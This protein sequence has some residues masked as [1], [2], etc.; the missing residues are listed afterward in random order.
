VAG[1]VEGALDG[2]TATGGEDSFVTVFAADGEQLWTARRGATGDDRVNA[3]AFASD[4]SVIVAGETDSALPGAVSLGQSDGYVRGYSSAG[5]SLFTREFGTTGADAASAL[6]VRDN[7]AGGIDIFTGGVENN[8]GIVRS[9]SYSSAAGLSTGAA[10]DIGYFHHG[11]IN[12]LAADG[13]ELYVAGAVG[14]DRLTLGA[15]A[16]ASVAGNEGFVARINADLTSS[17]LDRASYLG[18]TGEDAVTSL[19]FVDG[20]LYAAGFAGGI[21]AGQGAGGKASSFI[22]RLDDDG[23]A[24]WTRVF[25]ASAGAMSLAGLAVDTSGASALDALG[26][27]RGQVAVYDS[28]LLT[29]RSGLRA[30]DEFK[31][32]V[33]GRRLTTI[34]ISADETLSSL[35][36]KI[37]RAV[38]GAGRAKVVAEN[39]VERIVITPNTGKAIRVDPGRD[40]HDALG[41][42]GFQQGLIAKNVE[43]FKGVKSYGLSIIAQDFDLST[44]KGAQNAVAELSA[45]LSIVRQAYEAMANPYEQTA[46]EKAL[47]ER[48]KNAGAA[49]AYI[50]A[51]HNNY[52]AALQKLSGL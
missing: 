45:A 31:I 29:N 2:A 16:R 37:T 25:N 41:A 12:A 4:G 20:D 22:T 17:D 13:A 21:I 42:L 51:Q 14:A 38:A 36:T 23:D 39:G 40:G 11:A 5:L 27:P 48:R 32:G 8:R 44:E 28:T 3:I 9:F 10:R 43:G 15:T 24:A 50:T 18:S 30:G 6:L 19:A 47:A 1:A 52:L 46:E 34:K 35:A 7:G 33:D 26:L 49:P